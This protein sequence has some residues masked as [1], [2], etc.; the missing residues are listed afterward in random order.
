MTREI[1]LTRGYVAL[2]DDDDYDWLSEHRWSAVGSEAK[3][4]YAATQ[5]R[6][7]GQRRTV[8]MHRLIAGATP[9]QLVDHVD[10]AT[11]DNRKANMRLCTHS[12]N[13]QNSRRRDGGY[14]GVTRHRGL[15]RAAICVDR[16]TI[17]SR[18][19]TSAIAAARAY[20]RLAL[21]HHCEFAKLNFPPKHDW[22]FPHEAVGV[23]PPGPDL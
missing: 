3:G 16:R 8:L 23:W 6:V 4:V 21:E 2:V 20:D 9:G 19:L 10:G 11:L 13:M 15:W 14:K 7:A 18:V 1:P 12:Q 5:V 17:Q 22:L